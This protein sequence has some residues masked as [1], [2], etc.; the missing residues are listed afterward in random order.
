MNPE[1]VLFHACD[2]VRLE[3]LVQAPQAGGPLPGVILAHSHSLQA[4]GHMHAHVLRAVAARLAAHGFV[5]L[6]FNFR[7]VQG[8]AGVFDDGRGELQDLCGAVDALQARRAL[9]PAQIGIV[10]YSFGAR[11]AVPYA[12]NDSRIKAVAT[13]GFPARRYVHAPLDLRIPV[14]LLVGDADT[15]TPLHQIERFHAQQPT[16]TLQVLRGADHFYRG[17]EEEVAE[18]VVQFMRAHLNV[19]A[20]A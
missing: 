12:L 5:A 14:L 2:G 19:G 9:N 17:C 4:G 6:R 3:G 15:T 8:S 13:L 16:T 11:V 18:A 7:G 1:K 20:T 10:G